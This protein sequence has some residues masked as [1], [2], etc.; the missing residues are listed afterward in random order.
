MSTLFSLN[1]PG[2]DTDQRRTN[3]EG[4]SYVTLHPYTPK[5]AKKIAKSHQRTMNFEE[6]FG[7]QKWTKYFEIE[8]PMKDDFEL[9]SALAK[10]VGTDVL[11]RQQKDGLRIIE[12]ADE[13]QSKKLCEL[14]EKND[15]DLPVKKNKTLN[16]C[17]GTILVPSNIELGSQEFSECSEK[18]KENV[19]IQG[20][21]INNIITY[22]KPAK[23]RRKYPLR[24]AKISFE[25][26]VLPETIVVA[27]QR[28]SVKEYVPTPRQCNKC[29]KYGHSVK[30]C[31]T[32][33]YICPICSGKGH[34]KD[35]CNQIN[36]RMC[37]NCQGSHPAFSRSCVHYKREQLIVKTQFKE[38]LSYRAA[39][40]KLKQTG[41]ISTYNYKKALES[42]TPTTSTPKMP[43]FATTN[44]FSLLE[45]E[46]SQNH[47]I[48]T[49]VIKNS[50]KRI[51]KRIRHSSS[52]EGGHSPKPNPKQKPRNRDQEEGKELHKVIADIHMTEI[53]SLDDT[54]IYDDKDQEKLDVETKSST[55][56]TPSIPA[57][58][59]SESTLPNIVPSEGSCPAP[60][61][62]EA[63]VSSAVIS[64][65]SIQTVV[66]SE[67][68]APTAIL[69]VSAISTVIPSEASVSTV[70]PSESILVTNGEDSQPKNDGENCLKNT[71]LECQ[72]KGT[73]EKL[74]ET[75]KAKGSKIAN[76]NTNKNVKL[77]TSREKSKKPKAGTSEPTPTKIKNL[78]RDYHM[79]P[80]FKGG[81]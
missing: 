61:P 37:I 29:W 43:E 34:Q 69:A 47:A 2:P 62:S 74:K 35:R 71:E 59:T 39:I 49:P 24:I 16:V 18:I 40:N 36:N 14:I 78:V 48:S 25:G 44:R 10:K 80:G 52:D 73:E 7:P 66:L 22:I 72:E 8:S 13:E 21:Q 27:G 58:E 57:V 23:G 38:G 56:S 55:P 67:P 70:T 12:A 77:S 33:I 60:E 63:S 79:P 45:I 30:Y 11:F 76:I 51:N 41:E 32:D 50:P 17:H 28:L 26:R 75:K 20:H 4:A 1:R 42:K 54:I 15:P 53:A 19:R 9:Y 5:N 64:E 31:K 3:S 65:A 68:P 46:E 6:L 81:K